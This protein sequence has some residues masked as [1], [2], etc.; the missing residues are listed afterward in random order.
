V[1]KLGIGGLG[2]LLKS[3]VK[4]FTVAQALRQRAAVSTDR[5]GLKRRDMRFKRRRA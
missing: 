4:R 3:G 5:A 2:S 1:E